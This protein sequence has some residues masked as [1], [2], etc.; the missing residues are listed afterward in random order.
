MKVHEAA[1]AG[2]ITYTLSIP[3]MELS[4]LMSEM[5]LMYTNMNTTALSKAWNEQ[6]HLALTQAVERSLLPALRKE[7]ESKL[8]AVRP[9][10]P[11]HARRAEGRVDSSPRFFCVHC[12]G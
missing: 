1:A 6:R 9:Y 11:S 10:I 8:L 12:C 3:E 7:L 5:R 4:A 2:L